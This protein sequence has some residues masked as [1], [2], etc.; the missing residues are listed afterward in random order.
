MNASRVH[1]QPYAADYVNWLTGGGSASERKVY[2][3]SRWIVS[4]SRPGIGALGYVQRW[5]DLLRHADT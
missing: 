2:A 1:S 3:K 5:V 4:R